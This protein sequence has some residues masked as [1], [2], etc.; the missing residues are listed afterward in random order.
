[1]SN[2]KDKTDG[3]IATG[4]N[5]LAFAEALSRLASSM[6]KLVAETMESLAERGIDAY[7]LAPFMKLRDAVGGAISTNRIRQLGNATH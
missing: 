7:E 3:G 4:G 2:R 6:D 5:T 1:M